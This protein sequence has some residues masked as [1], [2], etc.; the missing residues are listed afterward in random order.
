MQLDGFVL[1]GINSIAGPP[2]T[3]V[4]LSLTGASYIRITNNEIKNCATTSVIVSRYT[5]GGGNF[6]EFIGNTVHDNWWD[7]SYFSGNAFYITTDNNLVER[8][9]I[10]N[11]GGIGIR[12]MDSGWGTIVEQYCPVQPH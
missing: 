11:I 8:N 5:D 9:L 1:D 3:S 10:Y 7:H 6:N 4:C 12:F 2:T